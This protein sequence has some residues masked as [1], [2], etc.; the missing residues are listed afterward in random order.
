MAIS[1]F[2]GAARPVSGS[3]GSG[4]LLHTSLVNVLFVGNE[5]YL[6]AVQPS[7]LY[8]AVGHATP[9]SPNGS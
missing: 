6:G 2:L 7:V 8:A 3:W 5:I 4:N 9:A 1:A